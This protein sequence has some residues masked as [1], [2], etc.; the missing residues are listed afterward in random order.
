VKVSLRLFAGLHDLVG[1]RDIMLDLAEGA[2]VVDLKSRIAEDYPAVAPFLRSLVFAID[3]EFVAEDEPLQDGAHVDLIPP[4][5]GGSEDLFRLTPE[6]LDGN[7]LAELVRQ[8]E[9]GAVA[10]FYGVVRNNADGRAVERLEYEAH[11]RMALRKLREVGDEVRHRFPAVTAVGVWHRTG[12]LDIGET[13]LL[14]AVSAPHRAEAFEACHWAVDRVKE[15]VPIWKKEFWKEGGSRW[16][17][18]HA[19]EPPAPARR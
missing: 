7:A 1:R 5:S 2:T 18:G 17:E 9:A 8:D 15:I 10:L 14:V 3:D 19:V 12:R 11:E 13:S 4:V 16:V 6:P